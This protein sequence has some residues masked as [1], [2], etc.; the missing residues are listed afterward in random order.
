MAGPVAM[1][2][3]ATVTLD[4]P[5]LVKRL[6]GAVLRIMQ[7]A[8]RDLVADARRKWRG[9]E[10]KGRPV[11]KRNIS[12]N[13]WESTIQTTEHPYSF[14]VENHA[15][16]VY[17]GKPYVNL[18]H[19]AGSSEYEADVLFASWG[20]SQIPKLEADL[21]RAI[22]DEMGKPGSVKKRRANKVSATTKLVLT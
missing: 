18:V 13:A 10:Y 17:S 6:D 11:S 3:E 2:V 21:T 5:N 9:W 20:E 12:I 19:R 8:R 7:R 1:D 15:R 22:L 14:T 16:G 4:V